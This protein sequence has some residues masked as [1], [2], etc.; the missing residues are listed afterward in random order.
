MSLTRQL[1]ILSTDKAINLFITE[2]RTLGTPRMRT[3]R[4]SISKVRS[5]NAYGRLP[6]RKTYHRRKNQNDYR[7]P[8]VQLYPLTTE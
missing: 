2:I 3:S 1:N 4:D 5:L 6:H 7:N 8:L